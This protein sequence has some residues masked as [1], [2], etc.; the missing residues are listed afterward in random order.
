MDWLRSVDFVYYSVVFLNK[1]SYIV[2][3]DPFWKLLKNGNSNLSRDL[4]IWFTCKLYWVCLIY[5]FWATLST[6]KRSIRRTWGLVEVIEV[7]SFPYWY[8]H[9]FNSIQLFQNWF[10]FFILVGTLGGSRKKIAKKII[11]KIE[12]KRNV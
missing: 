9:Y 5:R 12:T 8:T 4:Y 2:I 3:V 6:T 10:H 1:W 11:P 7:M